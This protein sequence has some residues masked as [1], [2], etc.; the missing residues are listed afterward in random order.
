MLKPYINLMV[1][2]SDEEF[3]SFLNENAMNMCKDSSSSAMILI[4]LTEKKVHWATYLI[5]QV[6]YIFGLQR[7]SYSESNHS[8]VIFFVI[9]YTEGMHG[10]MSDLTK[11]Q[12]SLI[13]KTIL[14]FVMNYYS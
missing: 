14:V 3:L 10:T 1:T 6:K 11:R 13:L 5:D 7:S 2:A 12:R 4:K 8:S 9:E